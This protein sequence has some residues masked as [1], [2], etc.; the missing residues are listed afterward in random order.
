LLFSL[1]SVSIYFYSICFVFFD[2]DLVA[3]IQ[4]TDNNLSLF[5]GVSIFRKEVAQSWFTVII[6]VC[7][8]G[9]IVLSAIFY[10]LLYCYEPYRGRRNSLLS[11]IT[12]NYLFILFIPMSYFCLFSDK[13]LGTFNAYLTLVI[14]KK[15]KLF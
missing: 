12:Q 5:S 3:T 10:Y 4:S 2:Y 11:L 7:I 1:L 13:L 14:G 6:C 8:N 9:F 15:I